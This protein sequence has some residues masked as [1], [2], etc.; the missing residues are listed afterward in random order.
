M[1]SDS[2]VAADAKDLVSTAQGIS[3]EDSFWMKYRKNACHYAGVAEVDIKEKESINITLAY[4]NEWDLFHTFSISNT[5][6]SIKQLDMLMSVVNPT[7]FVLIKF[8]QRSSQ[9][10]KERRSNNNPN[11]LLN[12]GLQTITLRFKR[13]TSSFDY[14]VQFK[15]RLV[16]GTYEAADLFNEEDKLMV[17]INRASD[18]KK[19]PNITDPKRGFGLCHVKIDAS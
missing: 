12:S 14:S 19:R 5:K 4:N 16:E 2:K 11:G 3:S 6:K 13:A 17:Y 10:I 15:D 18:Y 1:M 8:H 7:S 9:N